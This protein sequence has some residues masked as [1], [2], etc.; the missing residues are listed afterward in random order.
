MPAV[1]CPRCHRDVEAFSVDML[2]GKPDTLDM[3]LFPCRC[4]IGVEQRTW[5][6]AWERVL[7]ELETVE[8]V[9]VA[10]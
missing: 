5:R 2:V 1:I 6:L 9:E 8:T 3:D 10:E 7:V 4:V